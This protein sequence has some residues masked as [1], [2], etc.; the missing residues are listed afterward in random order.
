MIHNISQPV[1]EE[2]LTKLIEQDPNIALKKGYSIHSVLQVPSTPAIL[3]QFS[4][5]SI[6]IHI[7]T[8]YRARTRLPQLS[9]RPEVK[10]SIR[11]LLG[12]L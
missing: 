1:L 5:L 11:S 9:N 6:L 3:P 8:F 10:I 12:I 4:L 2:E 7:D